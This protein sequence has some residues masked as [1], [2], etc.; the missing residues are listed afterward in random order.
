MNDQPLVSI[1]TIVYNGEKHLEQ[2]IESVLGQSYKPIEYIVVDGGSTDNSLH[3]IKKYEN[4]LG[5]WI[6][7]KDRGISDAFNKGLKMT[8]GEIIGIINADDWYEPLAVEKAVEY[9][10]G[11]DIVYGDLRLLKDGKTDFI[12]KGDDKFLEN[13]MTINHPTVFVRKH[14]YYRYGTFDEEFKC[15]MD[16]DLLIRFRMGGCRFVH[17]PEILAN[18]RWDGVSDARWMLGCRETLVIKNKY[19]PERKLQNRLYF[20]KHVLAIALAKFMT[21]MKLDVLT[22]AYRSRISRVK[23]I[24]E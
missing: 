21:K 17:I 6:S 19:F 2:T 4:R 7:E 11:A 3:I 16:Y 8:R 15:A 24:Y 10:N 5:N 13:E 20:F 22:R 18:M 1:I 12:L 14:C 9:I 23:K